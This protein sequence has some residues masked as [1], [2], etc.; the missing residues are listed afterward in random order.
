MAEIEFLGVTLSTGAFVGLV[1]SVAVAIALTIAVT[2]AR[3]HRGRYHHYIILGSFLFDELVVKA[4]MVS[5]LR[6]GMFG[7]FPYV[8]IGWMAP[9]HIA[10]AGVTT[11]LGL[12]TIVVGFKFRTRKGDKMLM[13]PKGKKW[14]KPIGLLYVAFWFLSFF[15]GL[16]V[17]SSFYL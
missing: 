2:L 17:F 5:R 6:V 9:T 16:Y 10:L 14:H 11:A 8:D 13:P 7:E 4:M 12:A 3:M 15:V 1:G